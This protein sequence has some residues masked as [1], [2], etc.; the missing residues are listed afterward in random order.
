M[1]CAAVRRTAYAGVAAALVYA[2]LKAAWGLGSR[3]GVNDADA[4]DTFVARFGSL[5]WVAT[6]GTVG[7]ALVAAAL[8]LAL[9]RSDAR[10]LRISAWLGAAA[11]AVPGFAGLAEAVLIAAGA[12]D[13][14][15][16]GLAN[17]V[18][19]V[20]YGAFSVLAVAFAATARHARLT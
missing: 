15:D 7:L 3:V 12:L 5:E 9:L 2:A 16:T 14:H 1:S 19:L 20:T 17:W 10:P 13:A 6:W 18:F 4:F 11:L 8:L